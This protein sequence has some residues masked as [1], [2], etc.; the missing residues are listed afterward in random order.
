MTPETFL[1]VMY[2]AT[3]ALMLIWGL[4]L[5]RRFSHEELHRV[6]AF[7]LFFGGLAPILAG[8]GLVRPTSDT[9]QIF[10]LGGFLDRFSY[11]WEFFFPTLLLFSLVFPKRRAILAR[12]KGL[13]FLLYLPHV[14]HLLLILTSRRGQP[15]SLVRGLESGPDFLGSHLSTLDTIWDVVIALHQRLFP[16][17]NLLM[18]L[19][20]LILLARN[21]DLR[22]GVTLRRQRSSPG[23]TPSS[24]PSPMSCPPASSC[25]AAP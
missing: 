13:P 8:I 15:S 1:P 6:V 20:A 7:M 5:L 12:V 22:R 18:G 11:A 23:A 24:P 2:L 14:V 19:T 16:G 9:E 3:G 17:V 25:P 4:G 21:A 10:L